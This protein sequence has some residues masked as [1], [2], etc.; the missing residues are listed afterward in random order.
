MTTCR[1]KVCRWSKKLQSVLTKY[2]MNA[3]DQKWLETLFDEWMQA[4]EDK[5]WYRT[6]LD[7][8]LKTGMK[9]A[10]KERK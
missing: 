3:A 7:E 1:C 2:K 8:L 4:K 10:K 5:D 9:K 6:E